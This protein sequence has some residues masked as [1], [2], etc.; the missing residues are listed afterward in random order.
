V[1]VT[2]TVDDAKWAGDMDALVELCAEAGFQASMEGADEIRD[3]TQAL[4]T[5]RT[6]AFQTKTPSADGTPPASISGA[7]AGS[8]V[9]TGDEGELSAE[10]GPT[11]DYGREQELGGP[12]SGNMYWKEDGVKHFSKHHSLA[13]RPYLKPATETVVDSGRL[14]EIYVEHWTEAIEALG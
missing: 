7:L 12:M 3:V 5:S 13:P 10:V 1:E 11:T 9:V 14:R 4:L 8:V 2:A 6:H